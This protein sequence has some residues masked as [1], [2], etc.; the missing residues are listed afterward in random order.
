M[1]FL[2]NPEVSI[3]LWF[4]IPISVILLLVL[5]KIPGVGKEVL[6]VVAI[7]LLVM[8]IA[9]L[10]IAHR[11]A[12]RVRSFT[13]KVVKS[14]HDHRD[15]QFQ[16]FTE[17]DFA[18]LQNRIGKMVLAHSIQEETLK[19]EKEFLRDHLYEI[20]HQ[21]KTPLQSITTAVELLA[22]SDDDSLEREILIPQ[23]LTS[24]SHIDDLVKTLLDIARFD[25]DAVQIKK[26]PI[27]ADELIDL[28]CKDL[29]IA[30]EVRD[31]Q[32]V[33]EIDPENTIVYGDRKWLPQALAN[34]VKNCMEHAPG[35]TIHIRITDDVI[36]TQIQI[37]DNGLG[38]D[39]EDLP[40]IFNRF[41]SGKDA[42]SNSAGI[43]LNYT[44]RVIHGLDGTIDAENNEDGGAC[45][46]IRLDK[47]NI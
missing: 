9:F 45:F 5:R 41:Y 14:L 44:E 17:G 1:R 13:D 23:I 6:L 30:M 32:L 35:G 20:S 19:K 2:R 34:I 16:D 25:A 24:I 46:T 31:I 37:R 3:T 33:T 28:T 8:L 29:L 18:V 15:L 10:I 7:A 12:L 36:T 22:G 38:I 11:H 4:C 43:G 42:G 47:K 39:P 40:Y 26:D 27:P 21:I